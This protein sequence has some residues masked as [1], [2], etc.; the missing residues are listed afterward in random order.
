[1][2]TTLRPSAESFR[3]AGW[4]PA[5]DAVFQDFMKDLT[6]RTCNST[7]STQVDLLPCIKDFKSFIE[8]NPTVYQEFVR[9]FEGMKESVRT[10]ALDY[11]EANFSH[12]LR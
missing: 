8:T 7:Y 4:L 11:F 12:L 6:D 10:F 9:M 2:S 5:S 1:M 3:K